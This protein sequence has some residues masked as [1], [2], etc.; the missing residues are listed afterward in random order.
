MLITHVTDFCREPS[1][2][3]SNTENATTTVGITEEPVVDSTDTV[4]TEIQTATSSTQLPTMPSRY[5]N[6]MCN[7]SVIRQPCVLNIQNHPVRLRLVSTGCYLLL[8]CGHFRG[9]IRRLLHGPSVC[10]SVPYGLLTQKSVCVSSAS[11]IVGECFILPQLRKNVLTFRSTVSILLDSQAVGRIQ[12]RVLLAL[13]QWWCTGL[14]GM[15]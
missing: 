7:C 14:Y 6:Q 1:V 13:C 2:T 3:V 4:P 9:C 12:Q 10:L 8:L 15:L 5:N 11:C